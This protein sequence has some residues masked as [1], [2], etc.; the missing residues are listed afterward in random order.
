[1]PRKVE[2]AGRTR[3]P[4]RTRLGRRTRRR[5]RLAERPAPGDAP[6]VGGLLPVGGDHR[7]R[8][9]VGGHRG[10]GSMPSRG[11]R[12]RNPDALRG[13]ARDHRCPRA[14]VAPAPHRGLLV[15]ARCGHRDGRPRSRGRRLR[16]QAGGI[17][18]A[19]SS[20][21]GGA[22][23][24]A[25]CPAS[26]SQ[27]APRVASPS[28]ATGA[29]RRDKGHSMREL[30]ECPR[31]SLLLVGAGP[32]RGGAARHRPFP[33]LSTSYCANCHIGLTKIGGVWAATRTALSS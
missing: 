25:G 18:G 30:P 11:R 29:D 24:G 10:G 22:T 6:A 28:P 26:T 14:D 15:P 17:G 8:Q 19:S 5:R 33:D 16:R 1:M 3:C 21:C 31:C 27:R 20:R 23:G 7:G 2:H 4:R 32:P 9:P 13:G 12:A